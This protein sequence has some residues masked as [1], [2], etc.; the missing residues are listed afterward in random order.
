MKLSSLGW[1]FLGLAVIILI[2]FLLNRGLYVGSTIDVSMRQGE[3][4]SL[5]SKSCR[6]L[7][8]DGVRGITNFGLESPS[9]EDAESTSCA[10]LGSSS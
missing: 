10:L 9:R 2:G 8:L 6:Y 5:Y 3:G 4:K 7:Y 1:P